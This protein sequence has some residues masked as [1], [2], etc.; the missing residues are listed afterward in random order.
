MREYRIEKYN[1]EEGILVVLWIWIRIN[2]Q[3]ILVENN[4]CKMKTAIRKE[5]LKEILKCVS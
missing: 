5:I 3:N 2:A 4:E 1:K